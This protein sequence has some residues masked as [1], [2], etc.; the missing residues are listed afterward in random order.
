MGE[1]LGR[2]WGE[3]GWE[4]GRWGDGEM[5]REGERGGMWVQGTGCKVQGCFKYKLR[6]MVYG[7]KTLDTSYYSIQKNWYLVWS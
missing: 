6:A 4:R 2:K 3:R 7:L 5:G 1:N